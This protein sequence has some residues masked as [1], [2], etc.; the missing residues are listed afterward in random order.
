MVREL[1][2]QPR[3]LA[4]VLL[5]LVEDDVAAFVVPTVVGSVV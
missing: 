2:V 5:L 3:L 4:R 1:S